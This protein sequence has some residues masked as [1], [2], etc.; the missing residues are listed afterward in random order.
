MTF[1][2][3]EQLSGVA[4]IDFFLLEETSNWP[5]IISDTNSA[6]LVFSPS[7]HSVDA[8]IKPDSIVV[9]ANKVTKA[10]GIVHQISIKMEFLTR[11]EALE[12]LLEQYENKPGIVKAKFNNNFQ[13]IYGTD[14]EPLFFVYEDVPGTKPDGDGA[15]TIE[16]KGETTRRPVFYTV[17]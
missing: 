9:N 17:L 7:E 10:S 13:K 12:Q 6:Q 8:I 1:N 3:D 2:C 11:S 14:I 15:T 5:R 16:I 4:E